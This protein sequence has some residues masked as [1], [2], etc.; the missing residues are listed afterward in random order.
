MENGQ[1]PPVQPTAP[2]AA[3]TATPTPAEP[4]KNHTGLIIGIVVGAIL[5][6]AVLPCVGIFLI[7]NGIFQIATSEE[8]HQALEGIEK[9]IERTNSDNYVAGTWNCA[10]GTGSD[11][12]R[13]NFKTTI[14]LNEDMTFTYGPYGDLKNN[15]FK[16]TYTFEDEN[17]K[18]GSGDYSYYMVKFEADEY[19]VDGELPED[20]KN[21]SDMEMGIAKVEGGKQAIT[22]FT[23]SYNMYYCY[24][25]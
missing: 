5:L 12:D 24:D 10:S 7:F 13:D 4:K 9:E 21:L 22:I 16:G 11:R 19:M 1:V 20:Q 3:P 23:S 15:H 8:T 17:K 25:Y 6:F 18:N 2:T 14:K